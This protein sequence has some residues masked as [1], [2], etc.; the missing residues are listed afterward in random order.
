M[1]SK[2]KPYFI[3]IFLF[4]Y[5][6]SIGQNPYY[7]SLSDETAL[8]DTEIY[9]ILEHKDN[10]FWIAANR[11]LYHFDGVNYT[12]YTHPE[13]KGLSVFG[14][15]Y[16]TK[17]NIWCNTISGQFFYVENNQ[18]KLFIDL[19]EELNGNLAEFL[20]HKDE[21]YVFTSSKIIVVRKNKS[22]V[23]IFD[24]EKRIGS[25]FLYRDSILFAVENKAYK[26]HNNTINLVASINGVVLNE[27]NN[28]KWFSYSDS[29]Y[30]INYDQ[31]N[32][33]NLF[34][35]FQNESLSINNSFKELEK[36]RIVSVDNH[37]HELY[38]STSKG[39]FI[40]NE[41][42][43]NIT[44]S[45]KFF[46]NLFITAIRKDQNNSYW[47]S[48][49]NEGIF[50][51][52][53][54]DFEFHK[55]LDKE[56]YITTIEKIDY[57]T[58]AIGTFRGKL[59]FY[60]AEKKLKTLIKTPENTSK[61]TRL[62]YVPNLNQLYVSSENNF[63]SYD[64]YNNSLLPSK[65]GLNNAKALYYSKFKNALLFSGFDRASILYFDDYKTKILERKRAYSIIE[66]AV[67]KDIVVSYN[68]ETKVY[69][70]NKKPYSLKYQNG[71]LF[72]NWLTSSTNGIIW[73]STYNNGVLGF[74][75]N[76]LIKEINL[77]NG[78]SSNLIKKI[79]ATDNLWILTDKGIQLYEI[80]SQKLINY[81]ESSNE[82]RFID[83][84]DYDNNIF[85]ATNNS[86][87]QL[88]KENVFFK[89]KP[90]SLE[91]KSITANSKPVKVSDGLEFEHYENQLTF[92]A[93]CKGYFPR[94]AL[95]YEYRLSNSN[96][97]SWKTFKNN[98][99][100]FEGLAPNK[101]TLQ[102]RAKN[103]AS[104]E[105]TYSKTIK[106]NILSPFWKRSWFISSLVFFLLLLSYLFYRY[107][108][109][110][111]EKENILAVKQATYEKELVSLQLENLKS[112]MNPHFIFNAL[113][114]IQEYIIINEKNLAST[115]L[116]KFAQ[117][118]RAYLD[119]SSQGMI[120]IYEEIECLKSYLELEK[121]RFEEKL[122]YEIK[123]NSINCD[124]KIPTMLIQ[125][126]VENALKH[127]LLHKKNNRFIKIEFSHN[128]L[129]NEVICVVLDNGVGREKA[130]ELNK[131]KHKSFATKA[132]LNRLELLNKERDKN[133]G[134]IIEDLYENNNPT[135]TKVT[136]RIPIL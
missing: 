72:S 4:L 49:I 75:N 125:P 5:F 38:F 82:N 54:L 132:N 9:S 20:F 62:K 56:D 81:I 92:E 23:K 88:P 55:L 46:V 124:I 44:F 33:Q 115:Y 45:K 108:I 73:I 24:S 95:E 112:Q 11:G 123:V 77:K 80:E 103:T 13:K 126:Y 131:N 91:I 136:L 130:S 129:E 133:I 78:L 118:I 116:A 27:P 90:Q 8:P 97:V 107:Q 114:S 102:I 109:K 104:N 85:I 30:L 58:T 100:S 110:L 113:N 35:K 134:V 76:K 106:I 68:D 63:F 57:N 47:V 40:Y 69:P 41:N 86:L 84:I 25:P 6:I 53:S 70:D 51:V 16:D 111:K 21:L 2:I 1:N 42:N 101:Y 105:Y 94:G 89:Y 12:H 65:F 93:Y 119:H 79:V 50:I 28:S 52:P 48:S 61:I 98:N 22:L 26:I 135:G 17:G 10:T 127:G 43:N 99:I 18:M 71:S 83:I 122:K 64:L 117:L 36:L 121:L 87:L 60:D 29:L 59:I 120:S 3:L 15:K 39:I 66:N 14:L 67:T 74:Q 96:D 37:N 128:Q 31:K 19:K 7:Y 32:N 34:F